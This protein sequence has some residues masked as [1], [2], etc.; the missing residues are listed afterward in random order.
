MTPYCK[1]CGSRLAANGDCDACFERGQRQRTEEALK[2]ADALADAVAAR[3]EG[4]GPVAD[5]IRAYRAAR[6]KV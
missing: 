1:R 6:E 5:A 4:H 2:A 3:W